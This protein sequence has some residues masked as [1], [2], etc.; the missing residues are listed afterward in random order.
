MRRVIFSTSFH[1]FLHVFFLRLLWNDAKSFDV[2]RIFAYI[3]FH[4]SY[5]KT[6]WNQIKHH[7]F[8]TLVF[9]FPLS[10]FS[11]HIWF[12]FCWKKSSHR[13]ADIKNTWLKLHFFHSLSSYEQAFFPEWKGKEN[14]RSFWMESKDKFSTHVRGGQWHWHRYTKMEKEVNEK[15]IPFKKM[16]IDVQRKRNYFGFYLL[17]IST[18][19]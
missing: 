19:I 10:F 11:R 15:K 14:E 8:S 17:S 6:D 2:P 16:S 7:Y 1:V 3:S 5:T 12:W 9:H 4:V 18:A 13:M